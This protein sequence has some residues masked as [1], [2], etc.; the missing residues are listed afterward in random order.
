MDQY[1]NL[2]QRASSCVEGAHAKLKPEP[3]LAHSS[4]GNVLALI[5][6]CIAVNDYRTRVKYALGF[7]RSHVSVVWQRSPFLVIS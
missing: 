3:V 2:G 4:Q 1:L 6:A 5:E 7:D